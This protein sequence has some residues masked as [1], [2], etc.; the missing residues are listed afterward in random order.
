MSCQL[1]SCPFS[2]G[3]E[4]YYLQSQCTTPSVWQG[5]SYPVP[6]FPNELG[7]CLVPVTGG[8]INLSIACRQN[9]TQDSV[10]AFVNLRDNLAFTRN[11]N[12]IRFFTTPVIIGFA[13]GGF[14]FLSFILTC[15]YV[16]HRLKAVRER[17]RERDWDQGRRWIQ[18]RQGQQGHQGQHIV[19]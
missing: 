4:C 15:I 17:E 13:V 18:A 2:D 14:L 10:T 11:N 9:I 6:N 16:Q 7:F 5:L 8:Y 19:V 1:L 3:F 12:I